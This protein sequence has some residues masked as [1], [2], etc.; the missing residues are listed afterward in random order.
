M[1]DFVPE[2]D[3]R[4]VAMLEGGATVAAFS[5]Q[6]GV[7]TP[8]RMLDFAATDSGWQ[9]ARD[10]VTRSVHYDPPGGGQAL[11]IDRIRLNPS[12]VSAVPARA[13]A[14][15]PIDVSTTTTDDAAFTTVLTATAADADGL[16]EFASPTRTMAKYLY[17]DR[18]LN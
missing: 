17:G 4:N 11:P 2:S 12:S 10:K 1:A 9:S 15:S 13:P 18:P 8:Q 14:I 16:Q 7:T 6:S 5:S 3:G